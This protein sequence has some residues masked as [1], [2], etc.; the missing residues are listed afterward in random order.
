MGLVARAL[1]EIRVT[2]IE[3]LPARGPAVVAGNHVSALD[4]VLLGIVVWRRGGRVTRFLV[5][6]EFFRHRVF[7]PVLRAYRHIPLRRGQGN[8]DAL[9]EAIS[10]VRDGAVVGIY[11]E[12]R[13]NPEPENG[14]QRGRTGV[15][16]I[17]LAAQAAVIPVAIW[18]TQRRWPREGL[19]FVLPLRP[20]VAF[21]FG[22]PTKLEGEAANHDETQRATD[23]VMDAIGE[24]VAVARTLAG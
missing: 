10:T 15:A 4:G 18:G 19:R 2:G 8:D 23:R 17:A 7:G 6:A 12:G 11:P 20:A 13:V 5:A 24:Q 9:G 22:P 1:F 21:A 16:R 14:L 3:N